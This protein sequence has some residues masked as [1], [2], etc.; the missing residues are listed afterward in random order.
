MVDIY[1]NS[2]TLTEGAQFT[3]H[4][5]RLKSKQPAFALKSNYNGLWIAPNWRGRMHVNTKD[6]EGAPATLQQVRFF[7]KNNLMTESLA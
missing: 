4:K 1:I 2:R 6:K 3:V 5:V 7:P